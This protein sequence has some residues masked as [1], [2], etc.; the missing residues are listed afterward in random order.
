MVEA[1]DHGRLG[2]AKTFMYL[3]PVYEAS[4]DEA[5]VELA[6]LGGWPAWA[7]HS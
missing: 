1:G 5:F 2:A 3:P 6:W 7:T 4:K